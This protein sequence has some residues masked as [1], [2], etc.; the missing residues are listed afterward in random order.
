MR[1]DT[2]RFELVL[3][4]L[5]FQT[6]AWIEEQCNCNYTITETPYTTQVIPSFYV[7]IIIFGL[8][9]NSIVIYLTHHFQRKTVVDTYVKNLAIAGIGG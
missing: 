9:G 3:T 2:F 1:F 8:F 5:D 4:F 6:V 7:C